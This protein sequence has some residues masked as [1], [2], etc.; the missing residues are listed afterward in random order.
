MN[1]LLEPVLPHVRNDLKKSTLTRANIQNRTKSTPCC[2]RVSA[3]NSDPP[4]T[5]DAGGSPVLANAG[6]AIAVLIGVAATLAVVEAAVS[7]SVDATTASAL[8]AA[9]AASRP[10]AYVGVD[11]TADTIAA[12]W[13]YEG[14]DS[15]EAASASVLESE[16]VA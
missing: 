4:D 11:R 3:S 2:D 10:L 14:A 6:D 13:R 15:E 9:S 5:D 7:A 12:T 8:V 1:K 16:E